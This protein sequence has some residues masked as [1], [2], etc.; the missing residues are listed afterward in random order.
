[1]SLDEALAVLAAPKGKGTN[2]K[3]EPIKEFG[4]LEGASGPV[5]VLAGRYGPYVTDGKTNAT[6]PKGTEP[7]SVTAELAVELLKARAAAGPAK[8]KFVRRKKK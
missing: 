8:K 1:M 5:K 2:A 3:A 6:L 4:V 7:S